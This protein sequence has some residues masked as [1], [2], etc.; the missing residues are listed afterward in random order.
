[1]NENGNTLKSGL[2]EAT[3]TTVISILNETYPRADGAAFENPNQVRAEKAKSGVHVGPVM[4][5]TGQRRKL[6]HAVEQA[7]A[8]VLDMELTTYQMELRGQVE[9]ML[10]GTSCSQSRRL[11]YLRE[12]QSSFL[13][14][15]SSR[16][17]VYYSDEFPVQITQVVDSVTC[18][19]SMMNDA[20]R[21]AVVSSTVCVV[22]EPGD[23]PVE[24]RQTI[25][26]GLQEAFQ[27][28]EFEDNIPPS[29]LARRQ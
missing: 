12:Q 2:I 5:S 21:C 28:G 22:L 8:F 19:G 23:D 29:S 15:D 25:I 17:L 16:R 6:L 26:S 18:P 20:I 1:M 3:R 10:N 7:D 13:R 4:L 14:H 27:S 24:I 11:Q 9:K